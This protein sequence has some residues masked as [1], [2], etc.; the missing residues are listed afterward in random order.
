MND[1]SGN[2]KGADKDTIYPSAE[3]TY[4]VVLEDYSCVKEDYK[5]IYDKINFTLAF[6]G[7]L[8]IDMISS[9][10]RNKVSIFKINFKNAI[11]LISLLCIAYAILT[12]L[13]ISIPK[14][15]L[16]FN[17]NCVKTEALYNIPVEVV[18]LYLIRQYLMVINDTIV[19][20]QHKELKLKKAV[21][22]IMIGLSLYL[23][24]RII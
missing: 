23:V 20:K 10:E 21:I 22:A 1:N 9:F 3:F 15:I 12:L 19:K 17:S 14:E 11:S 2:D 8:L 16:S 5:K 6:C 24:S 7:V 18:S 13:Y 4:N